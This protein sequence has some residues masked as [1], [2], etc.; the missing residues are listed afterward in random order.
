[1]QLADKTTNSCYTNFITLIWKY[2]DFPKVGPI[3]SLTQMTNIEEHFFLS[4]F[5]LHPQWPPTCLSSEH[6]HLVLLSELQDFVLHFV[7]CQLCANSGHFHE[8][9]GIFIS[10]TL[11]QYPTMSRNVRKGLYLH[12]GNN[13][14]DFSYF[15]SRCWQVA[16]SFFK[17][18]IKDESQYVGP[19]KQILVQFAV[20]FSSMISLT[21]PILRNLF[22]LQQLLQESLVQRLVGLQVIRAVMVFTWISICLQG[23]K[24]CQQT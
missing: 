2:I 12:L 19:Q 6:Q 23:L 10:K 16:T 9:D 14:Y 22:F 18:K 15:N 3:F 17:S 4:Q 24:Q 13:Y 1:M 21:T 20:V 8:P 5:P 7:A 11:Q